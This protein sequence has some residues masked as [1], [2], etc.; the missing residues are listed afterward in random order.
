MPVGLFSWPPK[1]SATGA[2]SGGW[3]FL[4]GEGRCCWEEW[5]QRWAQESPTSLLWSIYCVLQFQLLL[6]FIKPE[7]SI[8]RESSQRPEP[9]QL[10]L[11]FST[12]WSPQTEQKRE[13]V[14]P[15]AFTSWGWGLKKSSAQIQSLTLLQ[16]RASVMYLSI[17][18]LSTVVQTGKWLWC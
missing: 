10:W 7:A 9:A 1:D 18:L 8:W 6:K 12:P 2:P 4:H 3:T 17:Q 14:F 13:V 16:P 15:K 5:S 11:E